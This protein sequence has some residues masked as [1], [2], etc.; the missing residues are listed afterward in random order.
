MN[1]Q[2]FKLKFH[3]FMAKP[4]SS[5]VLMGA[6]LLLSHIYFLDRIEIE[7]NDFLEKYYLVLG[8]NILLAFAGTFMVKEKSVRTFFIV[9]TILMVV[10]LIGFEIFVVWVTAMAKGFKN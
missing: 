3:N 1:A 10:F 5:L 8:G 4:Q 7:S 2:N 9:I 6:V